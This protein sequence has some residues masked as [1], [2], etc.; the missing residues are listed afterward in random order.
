MCGGTRKRALQGADSKSPS[1]L[2]CRPSGDMG[3]L[4]ARVSYFQH[5]PS[6]PVSLF[7]WPCRTWSSALTAT[8]VSPWWAPTERVSGTAG[9]ATCS[10]GAKGP[11][12]QSQV[13]LRVPWT[14]PIT[15]DVLGLWNV[16][17]CRL[18]RC[19]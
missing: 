1:L 15:L 8:P 2:R 16:T 17:L 10:C 9:V 5:D 7:A 12:A 14:V 18:P 19:T 3:Q 4:R 6:H 11:L 13:A